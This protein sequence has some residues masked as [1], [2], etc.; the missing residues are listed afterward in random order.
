MIWKMFKTDITQT[1]SDSGSNFSYS[2]LEISVETKMEKK[3]IKYFQWLPKFL[4]MS[5]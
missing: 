5:L 1:A 4:T 2:T 3:H